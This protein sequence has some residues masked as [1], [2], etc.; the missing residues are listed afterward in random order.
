MFFFFPCREQLEMVIEQLKVKLQDT[1][2]NL[3]MNAAE[4][5][6]LQSEHDTLLER[7]NKMLQETV[8]KEAELREKYAL[9]MKD[10]LFCLNLKCWLCNW[11]QIVLPKGRV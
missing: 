9:L 10:G 5:Q 2:H 1:Q 4:F 3:Q 7:H 8:A 6:A 11:L